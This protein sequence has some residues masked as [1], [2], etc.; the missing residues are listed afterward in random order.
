MLTAI[1]YDVDQVDL[2]VGMFTDSREGFEFSGLERRMFLVMAPRRLKSDRFFTADWRPEFDTPEKWSGSPTTCCCGTGQNWRRRCV[3]PKIRS[4]LGSD[5]AELAQVL[6]Q[7]CAR[8]AR[9]K[10]IGCVFSRR[11]LR[12]SRASK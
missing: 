3:A 5:G 8:T 4:P 6:A 2:V 12:R 10:G 11:S 1:Y 7:R 9:M